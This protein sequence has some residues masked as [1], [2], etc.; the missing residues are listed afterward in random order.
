MAHQE[1][2]RQRHHDEREL[3]AEYLEWRAEQRAEATIVRSQ[4]PNH[5]LLTSSRWRDFLRQRAC[6]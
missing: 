5:Y 4:G 6:A 3:W 1:R 2:R